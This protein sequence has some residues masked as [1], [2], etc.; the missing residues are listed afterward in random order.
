MASPCPQN[1]A[2]TQATGWLVEQPALPEHLAG[3]ML[4]R[5]TVGDGNTRGEALAGVVPGPLLW[6]VPTAPGLT[7]ARSVIG[8]WHE[9]DP[10]VGPAQPLHLSALRVA[11]GPYQ[12]DP[13]PG[14]QQPQGLGEVLLYSLW[15]HLLWG[16]GVGVGTW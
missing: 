1:Q 7:I 11:S 9:E 2:G 15:V 8:P 5:A 3:A 10:F 12:H 16:E 6:P 14:T 13:V 4:L